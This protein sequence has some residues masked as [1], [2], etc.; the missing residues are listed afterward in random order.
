MA[1]VLTK[2]MS[3]GVPA[4]IAGREFT[5]FEDPEQVW[6]IKDPWMDGRSMGIPAVVNYLAAI[7]LRPADGSTSR[8]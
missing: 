4:V 5:R 7:P 2:P 6:G 8:T 1:F 3:S